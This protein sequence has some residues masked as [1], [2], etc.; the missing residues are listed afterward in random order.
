M[1]IFPR[2]TL[3]RC[4]SHEQSLLILYK[5]WWTWLQSESDRHYHLS[6][7]VTSTSL[8]SI[9]LSSLLF[10]RCHPRGHYTKDAVYTKMMFWPIRDSGN[11]WNRIV[12]CINNY[13]RRIR[14][15]R[16]H[17]G[18]HD[19]RRIMNHNVSSGINKSN[20]RL[21]QKWPISCPTSR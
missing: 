15:G 5:Y 12:G 9:V 20:L 3:E 11:I 17:F 16:C 10:G 19:C 13:K 18:C 7:A 6:F 8:L 2:V 4:I 14:Y 21:K 1:L